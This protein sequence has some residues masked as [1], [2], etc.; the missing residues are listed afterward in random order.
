MDARNMNECGC[1]HVN[2]NVNVCVCV[3]VW[4][5]VR[6]SDAKRSGEKWSRVEWSGVE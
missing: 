6:S 3:C 4:R 2:V 1:V 5:E